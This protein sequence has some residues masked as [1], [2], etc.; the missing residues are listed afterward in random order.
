[1]LIGLTGQIGAGKSTVAKYLQRLGAVIVDADQIGRDLLDKNVAVKRSLVRS[2]GR[3]I[4]DRSGTINRRALALAAFETETSRKNLNRIVHPP[5]LKELRRKVRANLHA[6]KIVVI[7]A[8]L[9]LEWGLD[10][11]VDSVVVVRA[12]LDIRLRRMIERGFA[13]ADVIR[14]MR[15]QMNWSEFDQRADVVISNS[16]KKTDLRRAVTFLWKQITPAQ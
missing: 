5:L 8:A 3:N 7:D 16:G 10:K 4:V 11:K 15:R 6:N 12:P 2:F 9:L 1:M 14:R 13:R